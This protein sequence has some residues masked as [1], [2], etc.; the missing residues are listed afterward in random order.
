MVRS[1]GVPL[2]VS[3]A[4]KGGAA[5]APPPATVAVL[6]AFA[7]LAETVIWT[8]MVALAPGPSGASRWQRTS[9]PL[10]LQV[11]L[12]P[13]AVLGVNPEGN[14]SSTTIGA[15]VA[16]L[17]PLVIV[18]VTEPFCPCTSVPTCFLVPVRLG[19]PG[20]V[21]IG[22]VSFALLL[23]GLESSLFVRVAVLMTLGGAP[24]GTLTV[25]RI[26]DSVGDGGSGATCVQTT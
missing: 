22:V 16:T 9:C 26:S 14:G 1:V 23:S 3:G 6:S 19:V 13:V 4:L 15:D 21:P 2:T 17:P 10:T 25:R 7:A 11:K 8:L 20:G 24:A 5:G 12:S 18:N